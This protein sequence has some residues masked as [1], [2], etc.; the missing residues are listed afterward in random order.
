MRTRRF[1]SSP[2][3][4]P[5]LSRAGEAVAALA[6]GVLQAGYARA[7]AP[8]LSLL[9]RESRELAEQYATWKGWEDPSGVERRA[10]LLDRMTMEVV[11]E[12]IA[13]EQ[14]FEHVQA[15]SAEVLKWCEWPRNLTDV[16][17]V[18]FALRDDDRRIR[19]HYRSTSA[20]VHGRLWVISNSFWNRRGC[21]RVSPS[22]YSIIRGDGRTTLD[23]L[24]DY[25]VDLLGLQYPLRFLGFKESESGVPGV[26]M[27]DGP[28][29]SGCFARLFSFG[30]DPQQ[31]KWARRRLFAYNHTGTFA[32][33]EESG[34]FTFGETGGIHDG[35]VP[36]DPSNQ[37]LLTAVQGVA[38]DKLAVEAPDQPGPS[39]D[40]SRGPPGHDGRAVRAR[41]PASAPEVVSGPSRDGTSG[42]RGW[43]LPVFGLLAASSVGMW[44]FLR[45]RAGGRTA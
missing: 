34:V 19:V 18:P 44:L 32:Y 10:V 27:L 45:R 3:R 26:F 43:T 36:R 41:E 6:L 17:W 28:H 11:R 22:L 24:Q 2:R 9:A 1:S 23:V 40:G 35:D 4:W 25:E 38:S 29:G 31:G 42:W 21:A 39:A 5:R 33:D 30:Y 20:G 16:K 7:E 15:I 13:G 8:A 12:L 14:S 37:V